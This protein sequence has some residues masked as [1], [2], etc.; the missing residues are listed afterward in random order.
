[1]PA[2]IGT[3]QTFTIRAGNSERPADDLCLGKMDRPNGLPGHPNGEPPGRFP[4]FAPIFTL[5]FGL[6]QSGR[7]KP[8]EK[9]IIRTALRFVNDTRSSQEIILEQLNRTLGNQK[10]SR[11]EASAEGFRSPA[12]PGGA[13]PDAGENEPKGIV[14]SAVITVPGQN[15]LPIGRKSARMCRAPK[16]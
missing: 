8:K 1:M 7:I 9:R 6:V 16:A 3:G 2:A 10:P 13:I 4:P 14:K 5:G 15:R 12:R 11:T